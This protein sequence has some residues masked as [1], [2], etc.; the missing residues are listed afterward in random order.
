MLVPTFDERESGSNGSSAQGSGQPEGVADLA[1]SAEQSVPVPRTVCPRASI[2]IQKQ[3]PV[4]A[5]V[6][7]V[8]A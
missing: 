4:S 1:S 2:R 7:P 6:V 5:L 3:S 8:H